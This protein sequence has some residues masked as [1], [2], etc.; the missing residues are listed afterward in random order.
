[1]KTVFIITVLTSRMIMP[2]MPNLGGLGKDFKVPGMGSAMRSLNMDL[3]SD[4]SV[5]AHSKAQCAIPEGLKLGPKVDLQI[6]LPVKDKPV[7]KDEDPGDEGKVEKGK[8]VMKMY[9]DCAE[10]VPPGQPRVMDSDKMMNG[11]GTMK[12]WKMPQMT[13]NTARV[14]VLDADNSRAYWPGN[15]AKSIKED[16]STPGLFE[17]TTNYCGGTSITFDKAQDFLAPIDLISPGKGAVDLAKTIK[18]EWKSVPNAEAYMITAFSGKDNEMVMW[19]SSSQPDMGSDFMYSALSKE[20][21]KKYIDNGVLMPPT[22][23]SCRIPAGIFKTTGAPMI[24]V[25]AIGADKAQEK[26]GIRTVITVRSSAAVMLGGGMDGEDEESIDQS[27]EPK[28]DAVDDDATED[29]SDEDSGDAIDK[30]ND[31]SDLGERAKD[32]VGRL[33]G[34]FKKRK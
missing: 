19:T 7:A 2:G 3:T 18:V 21:V 26:D 30:V 31:A 32:A 9:W 20:E 22:K 28:K 23:T 34:L 15:N 11:V 12:D 16:S 24:S 10:T 5:D 8:F 13:K 14:A 1:M 6:D 17:L 4:K 33:G 25:L 29:T 27:D